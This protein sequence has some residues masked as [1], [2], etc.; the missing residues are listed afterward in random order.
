MKAELIVAFLHFRGRVCTQ[1]QSETRT[2]TKQAEIKSEIS[3]REGRRVKVKKKEQED[4]KITKKKNIKKWNTLTH[5]KAVILR[6]N[7]KKAKENVGVV[8]QPDLIMNSQNRIGEVC[9]VVSVAKE[10]Q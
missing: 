5:K 7:K 3:E 10:I 8:K 4:S 9:G 2:K 1:N 6:G